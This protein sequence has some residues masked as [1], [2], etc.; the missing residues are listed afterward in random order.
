MHVRST[1]VPLVVVLLAIGCA[2]SLSPV[3]YPNETLNRAGRDQAERDIAA[4]RALADEWVHGTATRD[5]AR[6]TAVGGAAGAAVGA[7]GGAVSGRGAGAGAAVGAATGATAGAIHGAV[8]QT[9]P[10][11]VYRAYVERCLKDR[12]YDVIGWQ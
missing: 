9:E 11:P 6:G 7:V 12:G 4:C 10:T 1:I 8:K 5:V 3:L 2:R